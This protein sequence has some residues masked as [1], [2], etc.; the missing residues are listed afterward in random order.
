MAIQI[1]DAIDDMQAWRVALSALPASLQDVYF[2]PE[3]AALTVR[4]PEQRAVLFVYQQGE[5]VWAYPFVIREIV[6]VAGDRLEESWCDIETP[7]GYGGPL[8]NTDD[9][10]FLASAHQ[11]FTDWCRKYRVVAE[12][13][14][15]HPL[16]NN[17]RWLCPQAE[18]IFDRETVSVDLARVKDD[19][20][21][22]SK[23]ACYMLRRAERAGMSVTLQSPTAGIEYFAELYGQTMKRV[24]ADRE[25]FFAYDYFVRLAGLASMSGW[26]L[27]VEGGGGWLASAMFLRGSNFLHYHLS[28]AIH[29][30]APPGA[31]NLLISS[32]ARLGHQAG[33]TR[34]H[35]GGGRTSAPDDSLLKFKRSMATDRHAF[36]VG[37]R[38]H[39][40]DAYANLKERW[41]K[42]CP[43]LLEKYGSRL[44]CYRY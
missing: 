12:F 39:Q 34:M 30:I 14:R 8:S 9:A 16:L 22:F 27:A 4:S 42:A 44:L 20:P 23:G 40:P 35:L 11:S 13:V 24:A 18:L 33:L 15:L 2:Q 29:E 7:Y 6:H 31:T 36:L 41:S 10:S 37:K 32:A 21:P 17:Q 1:L 43:E 5:H 19:M 25:Y 28:A 38:V 26:L 3:Y